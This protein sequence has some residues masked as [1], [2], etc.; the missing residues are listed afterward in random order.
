VLDSPS[1][2]TVESLSTLAA[3]RSW[4]RSEC[5]RRKTSAVLD[6]DRTSG[7]AAVR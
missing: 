3:A 4:R 7:F 1:G 2:S 5:Q 6:G